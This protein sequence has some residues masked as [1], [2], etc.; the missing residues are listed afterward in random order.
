M[1]TKVIRRSVTFAAAALVA[2]VSG[3]VTASAARAQANTLTASH[4]HSVTGAPYS[5]VAEE[6]HTQTLANGTNIDVVNSV[7]KEYRDAQGRTRQEHHP[8]HGGQTAEAPNLVDIFDPTQGAH[9]ILNPSR[10]TAYSLTVPQRPAQGIVS[11]GTPNT[12]VAVNAPT[13][14]TG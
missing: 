3:S 12:P 1:K 2:I 8:A 14:R 9:Y 13:A 11:S 5:S 4:P 7:N 10:H 6:R